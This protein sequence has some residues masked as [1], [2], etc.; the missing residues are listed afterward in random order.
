VISLLK[1]LTGNLLTSIDHERH[2][3]W[4]RLVVRDPA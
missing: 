1:I 2:A 4:S 3:V